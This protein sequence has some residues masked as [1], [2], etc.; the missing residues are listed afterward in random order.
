[1]ESLEAMCRESQANDLCKFLLINF[2]CN[3]SRGQI[4]YSGQLTF[5]TGIISKFKI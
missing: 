1:M 5:L 4:N 2:H 3:Y